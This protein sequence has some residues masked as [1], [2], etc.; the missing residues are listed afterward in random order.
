VKTS[1]VLS[2]Q[3]RLG[4]PAGGPVR[5]VAGQAA[6]KAAVAL[7]AGRRFGQHLVD[8]DEGADPLS[9]RPALR[10]TDERAGRKASIL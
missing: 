8:L 5:V 7:A 4:V 1:C 2:D 6:V 10:M 3:D 9:C